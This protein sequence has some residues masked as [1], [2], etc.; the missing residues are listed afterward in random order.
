MQ[1]DE[2]ET[3]ST[4]SPVQQGL[5]FHAIGETGTEMYIEQGVCSVSGRLNSRA[6]K[7]AWQ[8]LIDRHVALRTGFFWKGLSRPSQVIYR[9]AELPFYEEDLTGVDEDEREIIIGEILEKDRSL[10]SS[11]ERAPLM[12]VS[13][14]KLSTTRW[15]VVWSIHHLIHDAWSLSIML[16]ELLIAYEEYANNR[17]PLMEHAGSYLEYV[18]WL[19][20]SSMEDAKLFWNSYLAGFKRATALPFDRSNGLVGQIHSYSSS[21]AILSE[22]ITKALMV[23]LR[24]NRITLNSAIVAAWSVVLQFN[25]LDK[26]VL[27]GTVSSGRPIELPKVEST[28]GVFIRTL[29][30]R[31]VCNKEQ[32]IPELLV[33]IQQQQLQLI[34]HEQLPLVEIQRCSELPAGKPLFKSLV[35]YQSAFEG[36]SGTVSGGLHIE[37]IKS[38]GHPHYPLM[39]RVTPGYIKR[40]RVLLEIVHDSYYISNDNAERLLEQVKSILYELI[41]NSDGKVSDLWKVLEGL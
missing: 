38:Q 26:E 16:K 21:N 7:E 15:K 28:V 14:F 36:I 11:L 12:R 39:F 10:I 34:E 23:T 41:H 29:P 25:S 27:F 13:L 31:I 9:R 30:F 20:A 33:S 35:V 24:E 32:D 17:L 6:F 1:V 8:F 3:I 37:E 18:K 4:L 22:D 5:L 40:E 19:K 2:I